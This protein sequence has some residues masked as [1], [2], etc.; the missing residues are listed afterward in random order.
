MNTTI[1]RALIAATS[2]TIGVVT[3]GAG[4]ASA[5]EGGP[6]FPPRTEEC[7]VPTVLFPVAAQVDPDSL[8]GCGYFEDPNYFENR[9][10]NGTYNPNGIFSILFG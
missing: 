6:T 9:K 5:D 3:L 1:R 4:A 8:E 7:T 10:A 2:A